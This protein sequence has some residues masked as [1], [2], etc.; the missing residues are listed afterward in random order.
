M[1]PLTPIQKLDE[2]LNFFVKGGFEKGGLDFDTTLRLVNEHTRLKSDGDLLGKIL[3]HLI[4]DGYLRCETRNIFKQI[5]SGAAKVDETFYYTTFEGE[6]FEITGGY[7]GK[8]NRQNAENIRLD[9]IEKNQ[10]LH[11]LW[12][13]WLTAIL[14]VGT[15]LAAIYY[16]VELYWNHGWFHF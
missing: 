2:V 8:S 6:V 1:E 15:T 10:S 7:Q 14:A 11:R 13:T 5:G 12:M 9:K 16:C 3:N 4:K